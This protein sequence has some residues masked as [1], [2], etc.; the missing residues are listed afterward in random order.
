MTQLYKL[1]EQHRELQEMV[2]SG[3]M[4]LDDLKDTFEGLEGEF[5]EKAVSLIHVVNNMSSDTTEIDTE[6][7]RLQGRKK[8]IT[9]KQDNMR[10]YLRTNMEAS[11]ITKIECPLFS[12]SL[13]KGRDTVVI[14]DDQKIPDELIDVSV[15]QKPDKREILAKLKAG[16]EVPGCRI[17]KSKSSLRIK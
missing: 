1:S 9:N 3:D 10:E 13:A 12:I 16:E 7:K 8:A 2:S 17:E 15:V 14:E 6:I 4:T 11:G 5:N